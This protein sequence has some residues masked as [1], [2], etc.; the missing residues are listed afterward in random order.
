MKRILLAGYGNV[1]HAFVQ[2]MKE[3]E[4]SGSYKFTTC[5]LKDGQEILSYLPEHHNEF[6]LVLNTSQAETCDVTQ[7]C[8]D[9]G[10]DYIDMGVDEGMGDGTTAVDFLFA[11]DPLLKCP[12]RSRIMCGFGINPGILE[13][14]YQKYKPQG[15][16]YAFELEHDNAVSDE[17]EVFG[18]WSPYS[19]PRRVAVLSWS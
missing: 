18:T 13:H 15:P 16:H 1:A 11:L 4:P 8:I 3:Q 14:V 5:D 6:D 10:L 2:I 17:Y 7:M 12:T 19:M 9:Y